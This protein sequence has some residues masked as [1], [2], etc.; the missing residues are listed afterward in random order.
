MPRREG[1]SHGH[2]LLMALTA[3]RRSMRS[4][5]VTQVALNVRTVV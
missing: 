3:V 5:G 2:K 1:S 4:V